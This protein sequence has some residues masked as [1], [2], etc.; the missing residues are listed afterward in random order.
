ML[1]C[2]KL[3]IMLCCVKLPIMLCCAKLPIMLWCIKIPI[4]LCCINIQKSADSTTSTEVIIIQMQDNPTLKRN[5]FSTYNI[6]QIY[7]HLQV[8]KAQL[9]KLLTEENLI[10]QQELNSMGKAFYIQRA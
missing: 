6:H 5:N 7:Y 10:Y 2:A 3:P 9:R 8:R 1:G 4:M